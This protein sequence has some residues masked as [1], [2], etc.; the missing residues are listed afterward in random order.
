MINLCPSG[1]RL[2]FG[3]S[4]LSLQPITEGAPQ[5]RNPL[6]SQFS[7]K[8][9]RGSV[10]I[11]LMMACVLFGAL[12]FT[13]SRISGSGSQTMSRGQLKL[14]AQSVIDTG[15]QFQIGTQKMISKGC[16]EN[17][18]TYYDFTDDENPFTRFHSV[19][20]Y[21]NPNNLNHSAPECAYFNV[22]GGGGAKIKLPTIIF[23]TDTEPTAAAR[24]IGISD[25]SRVGSAGPVDV[26]FAISGINLDLCREIN[27]ILGYQNAATLQSI[28][29]TNID[30]NDYMGSFVTSAWDSTF[31]IPYFSG[32]TEGCGLIPGSN[33]P[34]AG[35]LKTILMR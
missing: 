30:G 1:F 20:G 24:W 5:R 9:E 3:C 17:E 14:L 33:P 31:H 13:Y 32:R 8:N 29:I 21:N 15:Q 4:A 10:F 11:I 18:I 23:H 6:S 35:Y 25:K 22:S 12:M 2:A 7:N 27:R 34:G 28:I 19:G 16:S 26:Q